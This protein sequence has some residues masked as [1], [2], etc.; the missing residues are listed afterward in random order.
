[1]SASYV[2]SV[3]I[4]FVS[5]SIGKVIGEIGASRYLPERRISLTR[6]FSL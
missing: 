4:I 3:I 2:E 6:D 1:L 5:W